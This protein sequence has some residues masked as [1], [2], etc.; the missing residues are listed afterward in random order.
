MATE[1]WNIDTSHSHLDFIVRH[2]VISKV[3]GAFGKWSG[4][5]DVDTTDLTKSHVSA[6]VEVA[7]IETR[8]AQRDG[9]L[10][11]PDFFD[12]EKYP[13]ITFTSKSVT[14]GGDKFEVVGALTIHGVTH[15]V[16]LHVEANGTGK[17]PYGNLRA[18]YSAKTSFNRKDFGMHFN[19]VL[20]N[21]GVMVS[22]KVDVEIELEAIK[23]AATAAA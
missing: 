13:Q 11:S 10:K 3:R 16:T 8:D 17:D 18:G 1:R 5:I 2:M 23:A 7:S 20:D 19:A 6:T 15:D 14:G 21:G 4:A 12:V 22:E 9:H